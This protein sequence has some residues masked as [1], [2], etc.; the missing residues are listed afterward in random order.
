[1]NSSGGINCQVSFV[2]DLDSPLCHGRCAAP[3]IQ[4]SNQG[5][6]AN[7]GEYDLAAA[8]IQHG[9]VHGIGGAILLN[10]PLDVGVS[11][12]HQRVHDDGDF[13]T[14]ILHLRE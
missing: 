6:S 11:G 7:L 14:H 1:M 13:I 10:R 8:V 3:V 12:V 2:D 9:Q 4:S 5:V